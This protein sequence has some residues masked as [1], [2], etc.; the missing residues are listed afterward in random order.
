MNYDNQLIT[1][2]QLR[3]I[4]KLRNCAKLMEMLCFFLMRGQYS[5]TYNMLDNSLFIPTN[6]SASG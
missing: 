1:K 4:E 2:R 3:F 5:H 6:Q